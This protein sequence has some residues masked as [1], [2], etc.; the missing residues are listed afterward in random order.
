MKRFAI[1]LFWR[2]WYLGRMQPRPGPKSLEKLFVRQDRTRWPWWK[3]KPHLRHNGDGS[4]WEIWFAEDR[5]YSERTTIEATVHRSD[6]TGEI[7]GLTIYDETLRKK[8]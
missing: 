8:P 3:F 5:C 6:D 1:W 7:V 4:Q 2:V